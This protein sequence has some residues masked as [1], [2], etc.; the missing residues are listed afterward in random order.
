MIKE[1]VWFF[2]TTAWIRG[3]PSLTTSTKG[4]SFVSCSKI[5]RGTVS[6][7]ACRLTALLADIRAG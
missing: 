5:F 7:R 2:G 4:R 6:R 1:R 3:K